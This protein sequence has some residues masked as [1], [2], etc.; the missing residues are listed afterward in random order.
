MCFTSSGEHAVASDVL[1][2]VVE[3]EAVV[4]GV[5]DAHLSVAG[6][7]IMC[8]SMILYVIVYH[9]IHYSV[10]CYMLLCYKGTSNR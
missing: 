7:N 6:N 8:Y 9:I 2:D 4:G 3:L 10:L 1:G 5:E